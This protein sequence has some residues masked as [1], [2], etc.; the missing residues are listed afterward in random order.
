MIKPK[1]L[2]GITINTTKDVI[3]NENVTVV[4]LGGKYKGISRCMEG[5]LYDENI[6]IQIAQHRATIELLNDTISTLIK[7]GNIRKKEFEKA[8]YKVHKGDVL[9]DSSAQVIAHQVNCKGSMGAGI[10]KTIA[11]LYPETNKQYKEYC[12][13]FIFGS[14]LGDCLLTQEGNRYIAN[15]FGQDEYYGWGNKTD[16]RALRSGLVKLMREMQNKGLKH[17]SFPY[18]IGCGLAG[19]NIETVMGIIKEVFDNTGILVDFYDINE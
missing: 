18:M 16:Y 14:P 2:V 13:Q 9:K 12:N 6:G 1:N 11:S 15:I 3:Q 8:M 4:I 17:V 5:D 10:A 19:G 7:Q